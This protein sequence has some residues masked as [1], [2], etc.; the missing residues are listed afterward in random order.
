MRVIEYN[1]IVFDCDGVILDSNAVK[2][3]A[4]YD[5]ARSHGEWAAQ[6]L[7][8][9][10]IANGGVSRYEKFRHFVEKILAESDSADLLSD[11]IDQYAG[12][13]EQ[14]LMDANVAVGLSDLRARMP[15]SAWFVA[16]GGDQSELRRVFAARQLS[17]IFSGGV[18]GSPKPKLDIVQDLLRDGRLRLPALMVGDSRYDFE[19]A[20]SCGLDFCFVYGWTEF[21][22]WRDWAGSERLPAVRGVED[23]LNAQCFA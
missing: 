12:R 17:C 10:H 13:V 8:E 2:T 4:F 20:R 21:K 7:K 16:S 6:A 11:L 9:Y 22:A 19:V 15:N 3:Q 5:V 1:A 14:G 23:L 18:F